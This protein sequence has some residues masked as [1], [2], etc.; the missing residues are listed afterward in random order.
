MR[1]LVTTV[2][3]ALTLGVMGV[4][5]PAMADAPQATGY[6][7]TFGGPKGPQAGQDKFEQ[8]G[9]F[10]P[11][12]DDRRFG[13]RD[14]DG[15][16]FDFDGRDFDEGDFDER[17][18][19]DHRFDRDGRFR[20]TFDFGRQNGYFDRWERGWDH[21]GYEGYRYHKPMS[22]WR[23][24]RRLEKQ[25]F[26]GVR[27]LRPARSGFGYRAFAFDYRGQPVMLRINPYTGRVLAVRH[28]YV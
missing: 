24:V 20:I 7:Q 19:N 10:K 3:T 25:G 14:F 5:A 8:S 17:G 2:A 22:Y 6:N 15:R 21:Q 23:L 11:K 13:D 16:A 12:F 27:G 28:I 4:A 1:K 26:Y 18:F 9:P